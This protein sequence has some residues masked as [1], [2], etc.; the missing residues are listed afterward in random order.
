MSFSPDGRWLGLENWSSSNANIW[1]TSTGQEK[2]LFP[3]MH[4][5]SDVKFSSDGRFVFTT[6]GAGITGV[7]DFATGKQV[8]SLVSFDDGSWAVTDPD[9]RYD[10][11]NPEE[12]IGL[13]WVAGTEVIE[14]GQLKQR[15]YTPGL[16]ARVLKG[17]K[18][19]DV[20]SIQ[21]IKLFP[22]LEVQSPPPGSTQLNLTLTNRGGG[23][24]RV[25]VRVNGKELPSDARGSRIDSS[26]PTGQLSI[27]LAGAVRAADGRNSVEVLV[28]D[29]N[30][31]VSSRGVHVVWTTG[32]TPAAKPPR[33]FAVV[34]G[35]SEYDNRALNLKYPAKDAESMA[36]A[37]Q[38]AGNGLFG[39]GQVSL[40]LL[41]TSGRP[42]TVLPTKD[43]FRKAFE[44]IAREA[45]SQDVLVIYLAGHGV[46]RLGVAD[47][48]YFLTESARG[49]ELPANDP[50][51]LDLATISSEELK[52]WCL[53]TRA[54]K[55]VVILDTC[56]AGAAREQLQKLSQGRSLSPDQVRALE[57]LKDSTGSHVLMGSA[58]DAVSY[59]ANRYG[60]G[61]LTYALLQGM[62]GEALDEG[63][64]VDVVKLFNFV[65]RRVVEL[66]HDIG[67]I[68]QP[69][70]SS[71]AGQ[72]FPIGLLSDQDKRAIPLA[73]PKPQLLRVQCFDDQDGDSLGLAQRVRAL[74]REA[75]RPVARG[76]AASEPALVYDDD[77]L[78]DIPSAMSPLVR[79]QVQGGKLEAKVR[80]HRDNKMV[81]D[82]TLTLDPDPAAAARQIADA[83]I[84][85]ATRIG[86]Q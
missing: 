45:E 65:S 16:F 36:L 49:T 72:S 42:G 6:G 79:Y 83:I 21:T 77:V 50:D 60:D 39:P 74:L 14:L 55:Q 20:A 18:L 19:P 32:A 81:S 53:R 64:R 69:L 11:F 33:L 43:E 80:I 78:N 58:A 56:A 37:L 84:K 66:A 47:Q 38:L 85:A 62:H 46:A 59:E 2:W 34:A 44:S 17:E 9:G 1:D 54:L 22:A 8:C 30:N 68:Q 12:A 26:A 13:H 86:P 25:V 61:L 5:P 7:W 28:Y 3:V 48:Y 57:L 29:G 4:H 63:N 51:M 10:A 76:S 23:L 73:N 24:G 27:D 71:P 67:G 70:V 35:V 15:F 41:T 31:L 52:T 75:S 40:H 82:D